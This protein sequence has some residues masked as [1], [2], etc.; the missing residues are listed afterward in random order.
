MSSSLV[1][2]ICSVTYHLF[3]HWFPDS[4]C[5]LNVGKVSI[6][7]KSGLYVR[8]FLVK[9]IIDECGENVNIERHAG[10]SRGLHLGNYSGIGRNS[11]VSDA[12]IGDHVMMGPEVVIYNQN[13][14]FDR[15]DIP[16]DQQG[17]QPEKRVHIGNDVWIGRRV[18]IMPGVTIGDGCVIGAGA[19]VAKDIPPYSVAVGNPARVVKS[20][21]DSS[22]G[23]VNQLYGESEG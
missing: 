4:Y 21:V 14:R 16:M 18:M 9:R 5:C 2:K 3:G 1:K 7:L 15:T 17:F 13:H 6:R 20:R 19:V 11:H 23:K 8:R 12:W 22:D 10:F